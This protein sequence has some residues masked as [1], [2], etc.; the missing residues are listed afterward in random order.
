MAK[1]V[2]FSSSLSLVVAR[3]RL[4]LR[5][6]V[7][8]TSRHSSIVDRT[9]LFNFISWISHCGFH[10]MDCVSDVQSRG[11]TTDCGKTLPTRERGPNTATNRDL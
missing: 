4:L 6:L 3:C 11:T 10:I 7:R 8:W 1:I 9:S 5:I 2:E